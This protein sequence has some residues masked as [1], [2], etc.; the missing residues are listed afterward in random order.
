MIGI[1]YCTMWSML[2]HFMI[3]IVYFFTVHYIQN[4]ISGFTGSD[5]LLYLS[6]R[7]R[8]SIAEVRGADPV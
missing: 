1:E 3:F 7:G 5:S 8:A 6:T 4:L 2:Y